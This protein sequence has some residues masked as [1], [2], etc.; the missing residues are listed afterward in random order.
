MDKTL[1]KGLGVLETLA[2]EERSMAV[3]EVARACGLTR[4]N[5]H[6]V[7]AT[8]AELG[9][10][11]QESASRRYALTLKLWSMGASLIA[12]LDI[13][14][15]AAPFL[16]ELN[17]ATGETTHLSVRDGHEI[18]YL[19]KL[20]ARH[21]VRTYT[22]VGGKAPA[23]CVA[24]GKAMLAFQHDTVI[25]QACENAVSFTTRTVTDPVAIR[26]ELRRVRERGYAVNRGEWRGGAFGLAVAVRNAEGGVEA[27]IG[28]SAPAD[29]LP[30]SRIR[31][32]V[33]LVIR[34]GAEMSTALG[35]TDSRIA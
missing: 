17:E 15:V 6:R 9:Y 4:S 7:L 26:E 33:P 24:T 19:D 18:M 13:K 30:D 31:E 8:L 1:A 14:Q 10:V 21:A 34:L 20:E 11:S 3:S 12:R 27:A 2:R 32:L 22:R 5:A 16:R 25:E 23:F 35:Y 28:I 29:R